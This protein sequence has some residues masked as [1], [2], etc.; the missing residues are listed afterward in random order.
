M[1]LNNVKLGNDSVRVPKLE[2]RGSNRVLYKDHLLWAADAKGYRGH[3]N[4]MVTEPVAPQAQAAMETAAK[5]ASAGGTPDP[6]QVAY[7]SALADWCRGE[8][9]VKQLITSMIPDSVTMKIRAKP[10]ARAIWEALADEQAIL[11]SEFEC[12][13]CMVSVDLRHRLQEQRCADRNDVC[14]H[15]AK[16]RTM[17]EERSAMGHPPSDDDFYAIILGS[18][19]TSYEPYIVELLLFHT[20]SNQV[21]LIRTYLVPDELMEVL[22]KEYECC[23]LRSKSAKW[24]EVNNVT[25]S[26]ND[27]AM[28]KAGK[29]SKKNVE[30][31]N[32][33]K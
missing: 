32:C 8:V 21:L 29:G 17:H 10:N 20:L 12:K 19:P 15:F 1:S 26:A 28:S 31:Y 13:S 7:E 16:L 18:M 3:L 11:C 22:A 25:M 27:Q 6:G 33:K 14:V 2:L 4:G 23:A 24:G 5:G 30:S 9:N